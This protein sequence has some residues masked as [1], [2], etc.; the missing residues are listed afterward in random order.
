MALIHGICHVLKG[1]K[2]GKCSTMILPK[3]STFIKVKTSH[4]MA[5]RIKC[6][7]V[8]ELIDQRNENKPVMG[9]YQVFIAVR[10]FAMPL[11]KKYSASAVIFM[12]R[13]GQFTGSKDNIKQ[14]Q[15]RI[16]RNHM[17]N[18]TYSF[19]CAIDGQTLRLKALF[20]PGKRASIE[21]TLEETDEHID[22][23]P[24]PY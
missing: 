5:G 12:A 20:H 3:R 16:L 2:D 11:I 23:K 1:E 14:L 21:V 22:K 7:M 13:K 4:M 8:Y 6:C 19:E 18:D 9:D 15:K 17:V 10:V 24:I